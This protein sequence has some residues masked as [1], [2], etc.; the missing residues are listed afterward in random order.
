MK[1]WRW[2][3]KPWLQVLESN[4]DPKA[5]D[6]TKLLRNASFTLPDVQLSE[7]KGAPA[8]FHTDSNIQ[9]DWHDTIA[10]KCF[11][12]KHVRFELLNKFE[13]SLARLKDEIEKIEAIRLDQK[14]NG[15]LSSLDQLSG[16]SFGLSGG[17]FRGARSVEP[18]FCG[19]YPLFGS[20]RIGFGWRNSVGIGFSK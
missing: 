12:I 15:K 10:E 13:Q 19:A 5:L 8:C 20:L 2:K 3:L 18:V 1:P 11:S 17:N 14:H 16:A 7:H 4:R 6:R 9:I